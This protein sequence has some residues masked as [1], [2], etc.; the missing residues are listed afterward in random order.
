AVPY[1]RWPVG[2]P[3]GCPT[4]AGS[5]R[6]PAPPSAL[7]CRQSTAGPDICSSEHFDICHVRAESRHLRIFPVNPTSRDSSTSHSASL[8]MTPP[9]RSDS[10]NFHRAFGQRL[11]ER[12]TIGFGHDAVVEDDNDAAVGLGPDQT[13]HAL[14]QPEDRFRQR[15]FSKRIA[16]ALLDQLQFRLYERMIRYGKWQSRDDHV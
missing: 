11:H 5:R 7:S 2:Q 8:G 16:A 15:I 3:Y 10:D 1:L 14:S 9:Q 12:A 13:S 4:C 6:F